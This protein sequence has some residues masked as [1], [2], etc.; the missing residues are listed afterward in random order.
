MLITK[1]IQIFDKNPED[2]ED[3]KCKLVRLH[4]PSFCKRNNPVSRYV[5]YNLYNTTW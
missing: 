2:S 5:F 1:L 3:W 4:Q